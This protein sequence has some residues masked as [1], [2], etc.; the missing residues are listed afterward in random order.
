MMSPFRRLS[1]ALLVPALLAAAPARAQGSTEPMCNSGDFPLH[2]EFHIATVGVATPKL[3]FFKEGDGCPDK[4][5]SCQTRAFALA[6]D[7]LLVGKNRGEWS[8]AWY[9]GKRTGTAGWVRNGDLTI[10]VAAAPADWAGKWKARN[11]S[12]TINIAGRD[13][14]WTVQGKASGGSGP[15]LHVGELAGP[16]KVQGARARMIGVAGAQ[17][18]CSADFTRVGDFLVV[19]DNRRCGADVQFDGVY[20]RAH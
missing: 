8:C 1:L 17:G 2:P 12:G 6:G 13:G 18:D 11:S 7:R 15:T 19:R 16:L 10:Q 5:A 14:A 9:P 20:A 4:G 3:Y